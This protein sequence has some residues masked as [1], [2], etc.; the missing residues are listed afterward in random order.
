LLIRENG[1][2]YPNWTKSLIEEMGKSM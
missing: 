1:E 2:K